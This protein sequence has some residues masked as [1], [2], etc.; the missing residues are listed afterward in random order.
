M[1]AACVAVQLAVLY[2][3]RTVSTPSGLPLDKLVHAAVFGA[4][5]WTG[6][7]AGLRRGPL[8][9]VLLAH[10]VVSEVVQAALLPGRSGDPADVV[11]DAAG[12]LLAVLAVRGRRGSG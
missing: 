8:V 10:A 7:R 1:L 9:A 5:L 11:A 4:V 12:V 3:P 2:W 6:V